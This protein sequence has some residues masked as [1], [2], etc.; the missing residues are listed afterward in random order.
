MDEFWAMQGQREGGD[1]SGKEEKSYRNILISDQKKKH[2]GTEYREEHN[3]GEKAV[4][5]GLSPEQAAVY[6]ALE[7]CPQAVERIRERLSARFQEIPVTTQLMFL[8]MAGL[9]E[10]VSPGYFCLKRR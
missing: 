10:Q 2:T 3:C 6:N 4:A 7:I 9:A 1:A 8:C 5:K